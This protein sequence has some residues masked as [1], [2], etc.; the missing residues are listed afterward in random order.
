[1]IRVC[2]RSF[3]SVSRKPI[4]N[5]SDLQDVLYYPEKWKDSIFDEDTN[6][7]GR[8]VFAL[9]HPYPKANIHVMVLPT[10]SLP[11]WN[12]INDTHIHLL[13]EMKERGLQ[14]ITKYY[15]IILFYF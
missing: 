11:F 7:L 14:V 9:N 5:Y 2:G 15:Y 1:M 4:F 8:N 12:G 13:Y 6:V 3:C 10:C